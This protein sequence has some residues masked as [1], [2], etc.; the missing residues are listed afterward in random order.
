[1]KKMIAF[2]AEDSL[3]KSLFA[4]A[5]EDGVSVN[6]LLNL[7][8]QAYIDGKIDIGVVPGKNAPASGIVP[9]Q[10]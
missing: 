6:G 7:L 5:E 9:I 4:K 10:V 1:M 3:K 2:R 8:A